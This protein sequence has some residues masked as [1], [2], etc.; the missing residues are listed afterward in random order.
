MEQRK[1]GEAFAPE[2]KFVCP[3]GRPFAMRATPAG[4][5]AAEQ[6]RVDREGPRERGDD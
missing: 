1:R 2:D 6:R 4:L 5:E 3:G